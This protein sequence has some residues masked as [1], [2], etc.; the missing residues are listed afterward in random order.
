MV[1]EQDLPFGSFAPVA[2]HN[3]LAAGLNPHPAAGAAEHIGAGVD[4][5][6]QNVVDRVV[7]R[8]LP[9]DAAA[10]GNRVT[11]GR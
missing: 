8:Q 3:A 5:V 11:H 4:R 9:Y 6:G 10:F 1:R 2:A 7:N